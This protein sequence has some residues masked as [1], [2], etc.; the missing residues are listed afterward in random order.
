M[1]IEAAL[2]AGAVPGGIL[3]QRDTYFNVR[4]GRLKLREIEGNRAELIYYHRSSESSRRTSTFEIVHCDDPDALKS[5]LA[6][7]LGIRET[8]VKLRR[9]YWIGDTRV[10]IDEVEELGTFL[11]FEIPM[12]GGTPGAESL[13]ESLMRAFGV[14]D[15][16]C[17]SGSYVD[18]LEAKK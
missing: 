7:I 1:A 10:H 12:A 5:I 2:A 17:I 4:D 16:M 8:V 13:M 6:S 14:D 15:S 3:R 9:L 18:L 11:E